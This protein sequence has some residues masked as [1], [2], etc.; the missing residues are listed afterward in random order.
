MYQAGWS[1]GQ[2]KRLEGVPATTT[3]QW[4]KAAGVERRSPYQPDSRKPR[5]DPRKIE[6]IV[7]LYIERELSTALIADMVGCHQSTIRHHLVHNGVRMRTKGEQNIVA[8]KH[9]RKLP[10]SIITQNK[11]LAAA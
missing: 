7:R 5:T 4:L 6:L 3:Y 2:I 9:G 8:Y 11:R 10:P 1:A